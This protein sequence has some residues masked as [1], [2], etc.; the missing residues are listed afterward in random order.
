M[1][2]EDAKLTL[3]RVVR[4]SMLYLNFRLGDD[5][6]VGAYINNSPLNPDDCVLRYQS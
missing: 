3:F 6:I 1:M 5:T 4:R 2:L